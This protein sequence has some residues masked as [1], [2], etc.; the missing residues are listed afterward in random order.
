[1]PEQIIEYKCSIC[2]SRYS[3]LDGAEKCESQ[4]KPDFAK[5]PVGLIV[6]GSGMY[7]KI[8]FAIMGIHLL[9]E[10]TYEF[11][12]WACRDNGAGDSVGTEC[13][14]GNGCTVRPYDE[15]L[16]NSYSEPPNTEL[17]AFRRMVCFLKVAGI[18]PTVW[19]GKEAVGLS[20]FGFELDDE[21]PEVMKAKRA[22]E[23]AKSFSLPNSACNVFEARGESVP[24]GKK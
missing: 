24:E 17:P 12:L 16:R 1:M 14:S 11:T 4:G 9:N 23:G 19:T 22:L 20:D 7:S 5:A 21:D 15:N 3:T 2:G 6:A 18:D 8:I 13:C 10:H